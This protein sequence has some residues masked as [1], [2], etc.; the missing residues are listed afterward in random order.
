MDVQ[1]VYAGG[2]PKPLEGV[3]ILTVDDEPDGLAAMSLILKLLG[4]EVETAPSA[5][6]ALSKLQEFQPNVL[7]ADL[8]MP[9][10]DGFELISELRARPV[11]EGGRVAAVAFS[12]HDDPESRARAFQAGFQQFLSKPTSIAEIIAAVQDLVAN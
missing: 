9:G 3:R 12:A 11:A 5:A 10:Q 6:W 2:G 8:Q 7:I 1:L 4:A